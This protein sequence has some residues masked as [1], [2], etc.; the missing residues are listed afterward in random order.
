MTRETLISHMKDHRGS[1]N[2]CPCCFRY[3]KAPSALTAHMESN[4]TRCK[5]RETRSYGNAISLVSGGFLAV[6]GKLEDG[7]ARIDSQKKPDSFW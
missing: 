3:F 6:E 5:I 4:S 1:V 7:T 2:Q